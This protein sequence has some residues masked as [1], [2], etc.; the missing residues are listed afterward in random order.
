MG[1]IRLALLA[2]SLA[3]FAGKQMAMSL[4]MMDL[5]F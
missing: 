5:W 2:F 4:G 3:G 1:K